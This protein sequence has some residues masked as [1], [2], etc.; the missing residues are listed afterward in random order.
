MNRSIILTIFFLIISISSIFAQDVISYYHKINEGK[1]Q[2]I[3]NNFKSA[4]DLYHQAFQKYDFPFARD[5]Y[6]AIELSVL[7]DDTL[8]LNYFLNKALIRGIKIEDLEADGILEKYVNTNFFR[9]AKLISDSLH[10]HYLTTI[11][12]E[13]REEINNMFF[14]DQRLREKY[15]NANILK[16]KKN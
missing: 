12:L 1:V 15:Y 7:V 10:N 2:I 16:K 5:C 4:I 3:S 9:N 6:N 13:L 14:E 8:M 11:N